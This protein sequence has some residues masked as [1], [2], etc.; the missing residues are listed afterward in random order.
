LPASKSVA[1][2]YCQRRGV[3]PANLIPLDVADADEITRADYETR[4]LVPVRAALKDRRPV[5][6]VLLTVYGVPLRVGQKEPTEQDKAELATVKPQMDEAV[7]EVKKLVN[8]VKLLQAEVEKE[9]TSPLA[10]LLPEKQ[11]QLKEAQGKQAVLDK[12]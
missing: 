12:R 5:P 1:E 2:Y 3:P 9:P 4:I 11:N 8:A 7:A 6:R 10:P